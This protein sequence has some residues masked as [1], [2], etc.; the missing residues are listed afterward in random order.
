MFGTKSTIHL[1]FFLDDVHL[2]DNIC[3]LLKSDEKN[4]KT[5]EIDI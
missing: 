2:L 1:T 4:N 5:G 3:L